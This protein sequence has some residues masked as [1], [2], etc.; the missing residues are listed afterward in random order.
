MALADEV[1]NRIGTTRLVQLTRRDG[2]TTTT[3][4]TTRLA[5]AVAD[6][7]GEFQLHG[8]NDLDITNPIHLDLA[9]SGV[10][11]KLQEYGGDGG[12]WAAAH[13]TKYEN[14]LE[15][16]RT[17]TGQTVTS[18]SGYTPAAQPT[19]RP[20]LDRGTFSGYTAT[21]RGAEDND[22]TAEP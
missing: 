5:C 1:E 3:V 17:R 18:S 19:G 20:P 12:D 11:A 4:N 16:L 14:G 6:V 13:R 15:K 22:D 21:P 10:I 9:V 2:E 7:G 8:G